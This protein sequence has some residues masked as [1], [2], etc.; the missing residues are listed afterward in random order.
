MNL[1]VF[2]KQICNKG[3]SQAVLVNLTDNSFSSP[4]PNYA[5]LSGAQVNGCLLVPAKG[6]PQLIISQLDESPKGIAVKRFTTWKHFLEL[7]VENL[8]GKTLGLDMGFCSA[9]FFTALKKK[10]KASWKDI[11]E[12]CAEI[13]AIKAPKELA[14]MKEACAISDE[15]LAECIAKF[16]RFKTEKDVE[17]FLICKVHERGCGLSFRPI[18]ASG[19]GAACPHYIPKDT[20]LHGGFCVLDFGIRWKGYCTDT[21][22]T[23]FLGKPTQKEKD[24]Y[25]MVLKAQKLL[26]DQ[27]KPGTNCSFL[28]DEAKIYLGP[29]AKYFIHGLGHG[30]GMQIHEFP[31]LS[32]KSKAVLSKG[33]VITIEPGVYIPNKFGIRIE[34]TLV[35]DKKPLILTKISKELVVIN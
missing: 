28:F 1:T 15:I 33:M 25:D 21:T 4:N 18:V 13:R 8:Q 10:Y 34:D 9:Q 5:Y 22:R 17:D 20:R 29:Y 14:I 11:S 31:S 26:C 6:K 16:K 27:S 2:Q 19:P 24:I 23:I 12:L 7:I 3:I 30:V 35:V 32:T